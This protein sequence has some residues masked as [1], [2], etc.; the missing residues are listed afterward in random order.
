MQDSNQGYDAQYKYWSS[1][2]STSWALGAY[3]SNEIKTASDQAKNALYYVRCVR[4][5]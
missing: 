1:T 5:L 2:P 3:A 4:N